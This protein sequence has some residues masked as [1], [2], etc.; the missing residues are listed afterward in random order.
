MGILLEI[1]PESRL[2][3]RVTELAQEIAAKPRPAVLMAKRL[4]RQAKTSDLDQFLE[5]SAAMQAVAHSTPEH[6]EAVASYVEKLKK[7]N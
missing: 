4:L 1:V 7:S 3:I 5:L 2:S 6:D